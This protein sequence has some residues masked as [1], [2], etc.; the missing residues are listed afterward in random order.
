MIVVSILH[1]GGVSVC[2]NPKLGGK[3]VG[4]NFI[5]GGVHKSGPHQKSVYFSETAYL[6][7][8]ILERES[9]MYFLE[10]PEDGASFLGTRHLLR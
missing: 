8:Y 10:G 4:R 6:K 2:S 5:L 9:R 7:L 3:H 1:L